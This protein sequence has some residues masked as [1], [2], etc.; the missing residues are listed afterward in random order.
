MQYIEEVMK[1]N[2]IIL[3]MGTLL[4]ILTGK[5]IKFCYE[6]LNGWYKL[7]YVKYG[8]LSRHYLCSNIAA[9]EFEDWC[10]SILE[11]MGYNHLKKI[12]ETME[13]GVNLTSVNNNTYNYICTRLYGLQTDNKD[14]VSD[15]Y[16]KV[17]RPEIQEFIGALV[18]DEVKNGVIITTGDFTDEAIEFVNLLP[19]EYSVV[20]I[21]GI[22]LTKELRKIRKKEVSA[23]LAAG[24]MN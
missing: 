17:G 6:K 14:N 22:T 24:L 21:D 11:S 4:L 13:G 5:G 23:R 10:K 3:F 20:L 12:S 15:D 8:F 18:H 9:Y 19:K 1:V 16:K 2:L 7:E